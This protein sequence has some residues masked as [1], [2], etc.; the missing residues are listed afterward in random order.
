M[1]KYRPPNQKLRQRSKFEVRLLNFL[2]P[3]LLWTP[4]LFFLA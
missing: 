1:L 4:G 2:Q 3:G